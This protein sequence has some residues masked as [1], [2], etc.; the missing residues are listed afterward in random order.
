MNGHPNATLSVTL[1]SRPPACASPMIS[2]AMHAP[3]STPAFWFA[4]P[5]RV[6]EAV[7]GV[8]AIDARRERAV[9][10]APVQRQA[11]ERECAVGERCDDI[12][13]ARHRRH[14][15]RV[16]EAHLLHAL[17]SGR[18]EPAAELRARLRRER[19]GVVL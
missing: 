9:G 5:E 16:D 18:G 7:G 3:S 4:G 17:D 11:G 14:A 13:G 10:A 12:P 19:H 15:A 1:T 8:H 2:S 6:G